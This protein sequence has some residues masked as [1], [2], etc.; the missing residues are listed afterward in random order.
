MEQLYIQRFENAIQ[1]DFNIYEE[2]ILDSV[3]KN[4]Q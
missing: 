2:K 3:V 1:Q 4:L